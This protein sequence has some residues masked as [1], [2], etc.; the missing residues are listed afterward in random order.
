MKK[1]LLASVFALTA[2]GTIF[3]GTTQEIVFDSS[4]SNTKI[5]IDGIEVCSTPCKAFV[6]RTADAIQV[7]G[8]KKG[9]ENKVI[10]LRS[11]INR[12]SYWN[13]IGIYS[14]S[15]DALTGGV[16]EYKNNHVYL[17]ME[18]KGMSTFDRQKFDKLSKAKHFALFNFDELRMEATKKMFG[19][20]TNALS[21]L[22]SI[23]NTKLQKI[24]NNS[25]SEVE[26]A[27][28]LDI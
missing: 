12:T 10:T 22:S 18:P 21:E 20:Y 14:W 6:D 15:T 3:K 24:I 25:L 11:T 19:E 8:K 1:F 23:E 17:Q 7:V 2:C 5:Y 13:L 26:L 4:V 28:A 9:Y 27:S 16:W